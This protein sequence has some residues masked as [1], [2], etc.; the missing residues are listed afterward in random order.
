MHIV[1]EETGAVATVPFIP[2]YLVYFNDNKIYKPHDNMGI[3]RPALFFL[4]CGNKLR[5]R[6]RQDYPII[7]TPSRIPAHAYPLKRF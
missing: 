7:K 2:E 5:I 6:R 1:C 4:F 3:C